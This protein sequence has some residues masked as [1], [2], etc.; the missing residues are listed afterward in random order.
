MQADFQ[1]WAG[2]RILKGDVP[3]ERMEFDRGLRGMSRFVS[4]ATV[5]GRRKLYGIGDGTNWRGGCMDLHGSKIVRVRII[6]RPVTSYGIDGDLLLVGRVY[7]LDASLASALMLDGCAEL[8][9]A[10]PESDKRE[11]SEQLIRHGWS[12]ADRARKRWPVKATEE[13]SS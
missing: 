13:P 5:V 2:A 1:N 10:L 4:A 3:G 11:H 8:Y 6:R 7:N 9:D 12:A